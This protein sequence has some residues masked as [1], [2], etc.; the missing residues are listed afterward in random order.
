MGNEVRYYLTVIK[1]AMEPISAEEEL[2]IEAGET[3]ARAQFVP[4][5]IVTAVQL[6]TGALELAVNNKNIAEKIDYIL[7]AYDEEMRLKT[8]TTIVMR[9]LMIV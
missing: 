9:N 4:S 3:A 7:E 8:N 5:Y 1:K 2:A 6:P